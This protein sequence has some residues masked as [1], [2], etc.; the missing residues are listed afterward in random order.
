MFRK[1]LTLL[2]CFMLFF[3]LTACIAQEEVF[4]GEGITVTLTDAFYEV[5]V[6][7]VPFYLESY[8]HIF[9]GLSESKSSLESYGVH[10]LESYMDAVLDAST[11]TLEVFSYDQDGI[12][13]LY[14]YYTATVDENDFGYM[15]VVMEGTDYYYT[16]NFGCFEKNLEKNKSL[17]MDWAKTIVVE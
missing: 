10:D 17:F 5:S 6:E 8:N 11:K 13:F 3:S 16:M 7:G 14:G 9:M 4:T 2:G 15:I 12:T 1:S